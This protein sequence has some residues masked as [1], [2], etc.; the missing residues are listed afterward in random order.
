MRLSAN[1]DADLR[2]MRVRIERS[3]ADLNWITVAGGNALLD[4]VSLDPDFTVVVSL[5]SGGSG[6][7][8][9]AHDAAPASRGALSL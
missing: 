7:A 2:D 1:C 8:T 4:L 3:G 5:E 9:E 6:L